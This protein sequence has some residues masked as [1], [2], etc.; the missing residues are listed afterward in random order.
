MSV[1]ELADRVRRLS[2]DELHE[3]VQRV[4]GLREA[5][6]ATERQSLAR[7]HDPLTGEEQHG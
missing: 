3:P 7:P 1:E 4:P 5:I 2:R 6:E